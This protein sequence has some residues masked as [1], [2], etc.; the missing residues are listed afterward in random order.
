MSLDVK[1]MYANI[2]IAKTVEI[3]KKN[4]LGKVEWKNEITEGLELCLSQNYFRFNN[5]FY[6]QEDGLPMGS[7]LM[8][9][10]FMNNL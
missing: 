4:K 8:A 2:P 5:K 6:I 10:I 9:E 1:D 7:P 3:M